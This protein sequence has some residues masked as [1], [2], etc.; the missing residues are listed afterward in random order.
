[1]WAGNHE[2]YKGHGS[3]PSPPEVMQNCMAV[4]RAGSKV[5]EGTGFVPLSSFS[6]DQI[7]CCLTRRWDSEGSEEEC[8]WRSP[9]C[10]GKLAVCSQIQWMWLRIHDL[11]L[12]WRAALGRLQNTPDAQI[13]PIHHKSR[14]PSHIV[15][16]LKCQSNAGSGAD[17]RNAC[18]GTVSPCFHINIP[19]YL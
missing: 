18:P 10:W 13:S 12:S 6:V 14:D 11:C 15:N 19:P 7:Q 3:A 1:M 2:S 8:P 16:T 5:I 4:P 17:C 9:G